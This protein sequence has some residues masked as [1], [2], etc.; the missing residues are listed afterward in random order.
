MP[1]GYVEV[2][3]FVFVLNA[4]CASLVPSGQLFAPAATTAAVVVDVV[5]FTCVCTF[6]S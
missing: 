2:L 4:V 1:I 3:N 5:L 6:S